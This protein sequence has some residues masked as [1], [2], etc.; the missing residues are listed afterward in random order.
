MPSSYRL[1]LPSLSEYSIILHTSKLGFYPVG[2]S[3]SEFIYELR[4]SQGDY[5]NRSTDYS[6][7]HQNEHILRILANSN[8]QNYWTI[9][10]PNGEKV[11][12]VRVYGATGN[13]VSWGS[14][15]ILQGT[16]FTV[17]LRSA[18]IVYQ[19]ILRCG[20]SS[21][22]FSVSDG[23]LSVQRFHLAMGA[24]EVGRRNTETDYEIGA[25]LIE[26]FLRKHRRFLQEE[27]TEVRL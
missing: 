18:I 27:F 3:D 13:K 6:L 2:L 1:P 4:K 26:A 11:G 23:N 9:R 22:Y 10:L 24:K 19:Y 8:G 21:A 15:I 5:L 16:A 14:W 17:A 7:V 25:E 12:C 20:F